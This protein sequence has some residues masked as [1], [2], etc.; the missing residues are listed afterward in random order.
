[1]SDLATTIDTWLDAYGEPDE[2]RR[3]D[4]IDQV[5]APA[6]RLADP[7][8]AGSG[9]AQINQLA[10]AALNQFPGHRFRRTSGIDSHHNFA[11]YSWEMVG[12]DGQTAAVGLDL[13]EVDDD[14]RLVG[15][16]GFFGDL[17]PI[18]VAPRP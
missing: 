14:G 11:R 6:G 12:P 15:V 10:A 16:V 5:W 2:S 8:F 17:L 3:V 4:L 13:A 18:D 9:H 7:P 1:M